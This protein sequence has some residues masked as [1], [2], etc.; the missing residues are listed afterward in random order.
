[1]NRNIKINSGSVGKANPSPPPTL[2]KLILSGAKAPKKSKLFSVYR[3]AKS[4]RPTTRGSSS[5]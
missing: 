4:K 2:S 5:K 3:K 1:M